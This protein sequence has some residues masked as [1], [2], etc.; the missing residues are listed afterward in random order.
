MEAPPE[1][2][3]NTLIPQNNNAV[4]ISKLLYLFYKIMQVTTGLEYGFLYSPSTKIKLLFKLMSLVTVFT[5]FA[6]I[7]WSM[8]PTDICNI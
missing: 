1:P 4:F 6:I 8:L 2:K 7:I 3:L 5:L